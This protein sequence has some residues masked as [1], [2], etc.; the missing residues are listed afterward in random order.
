VDFEFGSDRHPGEHQLQL[1][2]GVLAE[3]AAALEEAGDTP[4]RIVRDDF[5]VFP[6]S[7]EGVP[8]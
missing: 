1:A 4:Q 6:L 7:P 8:L 3:L 5:I 2:P